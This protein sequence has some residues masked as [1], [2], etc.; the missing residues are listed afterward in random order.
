[1]V[2]QIKRGFGHNRVKEYFVVQIDGDTRAGV[3]AGPFESERQT[4]DA[5]EALRPLYFHTLRCVG[6]HMVGWNTGT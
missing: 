2:Y 6:G 1:M 4:L 3:V 5:I